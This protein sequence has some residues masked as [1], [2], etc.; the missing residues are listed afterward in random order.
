[1]CHVV[2]LHTLPP[3]S[4]GYHKACCWSYSVLAVPH[5]KITTCPSNLIGGACG[6]VPTYYVLY[7]SAYVC[8]QITVVSQSH[9]SASRTVVINVTLRMCKAQETAVTVTGVP[10]CTLTQCDDELAAATAHTCM[11]PPAYAAPN[12][13]TYEPTT[14]NE[15]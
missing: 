14:D 2:R 9:W 12:A 7:R 3:L 11:G 13:E 15:I 8:A 6:A 5:T 10:S 1:M 4:T